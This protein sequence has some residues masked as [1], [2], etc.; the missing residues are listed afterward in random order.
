MGMG[1][2]LA[3]STCEDARVS[4]RMAQRR[5]TNVSERCFNQGSRTIYQFFFFF[6]FFFFQLLLETLITTYL[7]R[8]FLIYSFHFHINF[9]TVPR[10]R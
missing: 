1:L 3:L 7:P 2:V 4:A 9:M 10:G 6:L 8:S 5:K